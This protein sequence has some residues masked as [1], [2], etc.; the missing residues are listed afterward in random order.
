MGKELA[1]LKAQPAPVQPVAYTTG[2][3]EEKA[4]PRGCQL[5]NLHCRY[6]A[7]D[8]KTAATPPA[9]QPAPVQEPVGVFVEDDDIGHVRLIPHQQLKLK[10]GD[11]LYTT[12]PA[13]QRQWVG[14]TAR[15]WNVIGFT[16]EFRAGAEWANDKLKEKN[17]G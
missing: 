7:C 1:A 9:A 10:D 2:H 14:L 12:P 6:P 13:A 11:K 16:A 3:C 17:N 15:D 5:H 8:R 4:K